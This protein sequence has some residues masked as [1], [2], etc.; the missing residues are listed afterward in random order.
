MR[1]VKH[2]CFCIEGHAGLAAGRV[3]ASSYADAPC[4][5]GHGEAISVSLQGTWEAGGGSGQRGDVGA[6]PHHTAVRGM[7][8]G[9]DMDVDVEGKAVD[10]G[11]A[12]AGERRGLTLIPKPYGD[13]TPLALL[14]S[15]DTILG[16]ATSDAVAQ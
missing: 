5:E 2:F 3:R 9:R 6:P 12:G 1:I 11:T 16:C 10:A 15:D 13:C 8:G 14:P 7:T 4:G